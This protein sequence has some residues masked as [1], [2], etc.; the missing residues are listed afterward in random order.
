MWAMARLALY[1]E[2]VMDAVA[3]HVTCYVDEYT[4]QN[5]SNLAWA[6]GWLVGGLG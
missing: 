5:L 4:P 6:F 1:D 3:C 2:A